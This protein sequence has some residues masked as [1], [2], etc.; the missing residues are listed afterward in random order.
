MPKLAPSDPENVVVIRKVCDDIITCSLP[1]SRFGVLKFGGRATIARLRSGAIAVFS[2]VALTQ[3]V[4]EA[5]DSLNG[6]VKYL[7]APDME[8]HLF[9]KDWR[10]AYPDAAIIAPE[11][12]W[13]KRQKKPETAGPKFEHIFTAENKETLHISDEFAADFNV[14]YVNGHANREIVL[15]H[16]P[17]ATLIQADLFFNPPGYEQYRKDKEGPL[18]G[19]ANK[20]YLSI[21]SAKGSATGQQR[22]LWYLMSTGDREA[23]KR[24]VQK[25]DGWEFDR[26]IPCHGDTVDQGAKDMF[27]K[28]FQWFLA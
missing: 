11:G 25:I 19:L 17:T 10:N 28:L 8:H 27:R 13:E 7:I 20:L 5:V 2:P 24:S 12:L 23:F 4:I 26:A 15:L 22:V 16:K 14:E 6:M 21:M 1:F 3:S 9:L 18:S